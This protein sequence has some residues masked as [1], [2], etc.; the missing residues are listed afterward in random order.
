MDVPNKLAVEYTLIVVSWTTDTA[1]HAYLFS[2]LFPDQRKS[3]ETWIFT[4]DLLNELWNGLPQWLSSKE[5]ACSAGFPGDTASIPGLEGSPGGGHG[6]P[7]R[8]ACL[9]NPMERGV[10]Q[11]TVHRV[12]KSQTWLKQ[13]CTL[14]THTLVAQLV[15]NLQFGRPGF[16]PWIAKISWRRERQPTPVFWPGEIHG[17]YSPWGRKEWDMTE[18]LSLLWNVCQRK[19]LLL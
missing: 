10:W 5:S 11:A 13:L 17:L 19:N 18:R 16:D 2:L 6:S 8:Y 15:K 9:E 12:A 1:L 3:Y 4:T 7:P 14:H